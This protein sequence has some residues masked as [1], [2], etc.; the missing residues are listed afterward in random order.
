MYSNES[1]SVPADVPLY[2][3]QP[4]KR[5]SARGCSLLLTTGSPPA[6]ETWQIRGA[7][8]CPCL[9][10]SSGTE[11][12]EAKPGALPSGAN[13]ACAA[14]SVSTG[15]DGDAEREP[16]PPL[17]PARTGRASTPA[18]LGP[19]GGQ[20]RAPG[21]QAR[22][23]CPAPRPGGARLSPGAGR[24][25]SGSGNAEPPPLRPRPGP[26]PLRGRPGAGVPPRS[27]LRAGTGRD[28]TGGGPGRP[29]GTAGSHRSGGG[30]GGDRGGA[31]APEG[32]P[33]GPAR[34]LAAPRA[35]GVRPGS[36]R[37]QEGQRRQP[38]P[39][40]SRRK[41]GTKIPCPCLLPAAFFVHRGT[42]RGALPSVHFVCLFFFF[43][44]RRIYSEQEEKK[45]SP[46]NFC[47]RFQDVV[48]KWGAKS[49]FPLVSW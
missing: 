42:S 13:L 22:P 40:R 15:R 37:P 41:L 8:P 14:P 20:R 10:V 25:R 3:P 31:Q 49:R 30:R 4:Q 43:I 27:L 26:R 11:P 9:W 17:T 6:P 36:G 19:S 28:A 24:G 46:C 48:F 34:L 32:P 29:A 47:K 16:G 18:R 23:L 35:A 2:F 5:G 44:A 21:G 7:G 1:G 38:R 39:G 12:D 33:G 45:K